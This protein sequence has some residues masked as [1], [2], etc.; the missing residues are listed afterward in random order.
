MK[1][2]ASPEIFGIAD[3][4]SWSESAAKQ[5]VR[6]G[7]VGDPV[8]HSL[9]PL[10]QNAALR[11]CGIK[12]SYAA[13]KIQSSEL[14]E[15]ISLFRANGFLGF[16]VTLPHKAAAAEF[17]DELDGDAPAIGAINTVTVRNQKTIGSNTDGIGFARA[18]RDDFSV[19][20]RDLRILLIGA[21]GAAH[22]I[23]YECAR[24]NCER[25][26][27]ANRTKSS[28]ERLAKKL[29]HF[30]SGPRVLGP[31]PRLHAMGLTESEL[32]AQI[33]NID[34]I[35]NATPVG[36]GPSDQA[37]L[38]A[39]ILEPHLMV[40]DTTYGSERTPL[41]RAASATGARG[42]NGVSML[43]HQG[44][45]AFEIWHGREA[46]LAAMRAALVNKS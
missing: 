8:E 27:I 4:R 26:V 35:V 11:E 38:P 37:I 13:F 42:A 18:I 6:F 40:Y 2:Q 33:G 46:P 32:R 45:R 5:P 36:L 14:E 12:M 41:L 7:V 1:K 3:L 30:F 17:M 22:G 34:L 44:V 19:D 16:N 23:A 29:H 15:A 10:I 9:S 25:L 39:H 43:L 28:A 24:E 20:L 21:G 31:V